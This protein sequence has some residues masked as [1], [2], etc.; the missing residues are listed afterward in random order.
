MERAQRQARRSFQVTL[1]LVAAG[2]LLALAGDRLTWA[3]VEIS[4][5]VPDLGRTRIGETAVTGDD[6]SL[7]SPLAMFTLLVAL[8]TVV[9]RGRGRWPV[10]LALIA[11]GALLVVVSMETYTDID[12]SALQHAHA[13][14]QGTPAAEDGGITSVTTASTSPLGALTVN[15]GG[16]LLVAA[17]AETL[18]RGR[19]WPA[20]GE[21][22]RAPP[23]RTDARTEPIQDAAEADEPPWQGD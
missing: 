5:E 9:T 17:G 18:R 15:A 16:L 3:T 14:L 19:S 6:V 1:V 22:F 7:V 4:T 12:T 10:G 13:D 2:V 11:L 21:A 8:G 20:M 23:D